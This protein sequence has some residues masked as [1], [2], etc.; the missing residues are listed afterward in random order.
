MEQS[1]FGRL[2]GVLVAPAKTFKS[3]SEKPTWVV[4]LLVLIV[5]GVGV[6]MMMSGKMDWAEMTRDQMAAQGREIPEDQLEKIIDFQEKF[7]P[8]MMIGGGAIGTPLVYLLV[9][10]IFMV[11][12]KMLG[13]D[14]DFVRSLSVVLH[15]MMPRAV[16]A[17][18]SFPVILGKQQLDFEELKDGSV[19]VS[20]LGAFAPEDA[21]P[22]LVALLSSIDLFSIWVVF[23]LVIGYST[24]AR[25]S[26]GAAAGGI[27]A[28]WLVYVLGKIGLSTLGS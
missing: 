26:K 23:L 17:L 22:A 28:L 12:F 27:V 21:G 1:S 25:V 14:L 18:L 16:L 4:A 2:V 13:G 7:G 15:G 9:A 19:L 5:L 10:L 8:A 24:V 3:I 11:V 6:T 20:N